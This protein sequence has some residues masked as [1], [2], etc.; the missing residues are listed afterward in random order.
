M[1]RCYNRARGAGKEHFRVEPAGRVQRSMIGCRGLRA[2]GNW[3][4]DSA[5]QVSPQDDACQ[6]RK[7]NLTAFK[8]D[9]APSISQFARSGRYCVSS[10]SCGEVFVNCLLTYQSFV[11]RCFV[12][13]LDCA[14]KPASDVDTRPEV[15]MPSIHGQTMQGSFCHTKRNT[16]SCG[17]MV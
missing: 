8:R 9:A 11:G 7:L 14:L 17:E 4:T 15:F 13:H 1:R 16:Q 6:L 10:E 12:F 3:V 5:V 2:I